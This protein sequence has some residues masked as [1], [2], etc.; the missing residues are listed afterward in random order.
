MVCFILISQFATW[1]WIPWRRHS[2]RAIVIHCLAH[3]IW[4]ITGC[5]NVSSSCSLICCFHM[6]RSI[7]KWPLAIKPSFIF[8]ISMV[9]SLRRRSSW[10][11]RLIVVFN[12]RIYRSILSKCFLFELFH[13]CDCKLSVYFCLHFVKF[14]NLIRD[15]RTP[16]I[17]VHYQI[18]SIKIIFILFCKLAKW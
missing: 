18:F 16:I 8:L 1:C 14:V 15:Q 2:L 4:N 11:L 10:T 13:C 9:L 7:D 12:K 17:F 3:V 6:L 5:Q